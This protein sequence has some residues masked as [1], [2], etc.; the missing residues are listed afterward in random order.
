MSAIQTD[1][2]ETLQAM[3]GTITQVV[4]ITRLADRAGTQMNDTR[5]ATEA[6]VNSVRS[7]SVTTKTQGEASQKLLSRA[8]DLISASQRTLEELE[9]QRA[10][11]EKLTDSASALVR[12]VSEFKLPA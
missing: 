9:H 12:T 2:T 5:A 4:D 1:T 7:I 3:N 8:Y 11:T 10:D 6:L